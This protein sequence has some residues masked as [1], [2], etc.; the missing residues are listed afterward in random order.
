MKKRLF[1]LFLALVL[2]LGL[3]PA[4]AR[5][6]DGPVIRCGS[7]TAPQQNSIYLPVEAESLENLAAWS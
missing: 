5:A 4:Q 2:V 3:V 1:C 6:A 7:A